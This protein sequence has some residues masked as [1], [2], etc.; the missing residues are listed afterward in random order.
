MATTPKKPENDPPTEVLAKAR[1]RTFTAKYKRKI[2]KLADACTEH[3]DLGTL[4]RRE[5][6]YSSHLTMWRTQRDKGALQGLT[7]KTRGPKPTTRGADDAELSALRQELA[8]LKARLAR[9]EA[10]VDVQKKLASL[11]TTELGEAS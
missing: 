8:R 6:L 3:G 11:W 2:L 10:L 5:G 9:A 1:R 4:L 7:P